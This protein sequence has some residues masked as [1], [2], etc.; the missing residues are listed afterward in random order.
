MNNQS[1]N[2]ES[3]SYQTHIFCRFH[4]IAKRKYDV[5]IT[6]K[7]LLQYGTQYLLSYFLLC[8]YRLWSSKWLPRLE[9]ML[10]KS[11]SSCVTQ[12]A[13]KNIFWSQLKPFSPSDSVGRATE[14]CT[15]DLDGA[16]ERA[17]RC[18]FSWPV[19][20]NRSKSLFSTKLLYL[21]NFHIF[22]SINLHV[23]WHLKF[24][25]TGIRVEIG[26]KCF[27]LYGYL[28]QIVQFLL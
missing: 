4:M 24:T 16:L 2:D 8:C 3:T 19:R 28:W 9:Q 25:L 26:L 27:S 14:R 15:N 21:E 20:P 11:L 18:A 5:W 17:A 6:K 22:L 12:S 1:L 23:Y 7:I 13:T 10:Y